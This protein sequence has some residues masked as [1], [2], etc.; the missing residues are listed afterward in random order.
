MEP[1]DLLSTVAVKP[2]MDL[3][4][5][6]SSM[7]LFTIYSSTIHVLRCHLTVKDIVLF[8]VNGICYLMPSALSFLLSW[9]LVDK[10]ENLIKYFGISRYDSVCENR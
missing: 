3:F 8:T 7:E 4:I 10:M 9:Y 2:S 5:T 6:L 1:S